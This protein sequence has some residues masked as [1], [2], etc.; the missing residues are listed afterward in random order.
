MPKL[1]AIPDHLTAW[2]LGSPA[3]L[4]GQVAAWCQGRSSQWPC[5]RAL[6]LQFNPTCA[7]CGGKKGLQVHHMVP[8]HLSPSRELDTKN[9]I[10]LCEDNCCHLMVGHLGSFLSFNP[11]VEQDAGRQLTKI[12]NR[13]RIHATAAADTLRL[14]LPP[15]LPP[16]GASDEPGVDLTRPGCPGEGALW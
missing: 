11:D 9:L 1:S 15:L 16:I 8:V 12:K 5:V 7:A 13:P 6:F 4:L 2:V 3:S 10:V 14:N